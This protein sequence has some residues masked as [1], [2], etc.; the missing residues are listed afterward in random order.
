MA[1]RIQSPSSI[2]TYKQCPRKYYYIYI[3]KLKTKPSIHLIR[4]SIAHKIL[5][6][7]F[8]ID[9]D[10]LPDSGYVFLLI[11]LLNDFLN[12]EWKNS[13]KELDELKLKEGESIF[14][15]EETKKML[16]NWLNEFLKKLQKEMKA[17]N[18][19]FKEAFK[20]WVP[21]REEKYESEKH[22]V[23]GYIDAIHNIDDEVIV[24]DYK[25]SKCD[26][27][28]TEYELQLAIYALMYKEKHG[29]F[30]KKAG[31]NFL[32]HGERV[33]NVDEELVKKAILECELIQLNTQTD[34][35]VDYPRKTS[36]LCKWHSGECDF[37]K[38]CIENKQ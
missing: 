4:G 5:E 6:D 28:T 26:K 38:I 8:E 16:S 18:I 3:K 25:T 37:Y 21:S 11:G 20:K 9:I 31:I 17:K 22:K 35:I 33:I 2:N 1:P 19:S 23:M 7:F 24:M 27:I 32:R 10:K 36:P 14:Y 29:K 12:R 34:D 15:Y 30:P 13:K